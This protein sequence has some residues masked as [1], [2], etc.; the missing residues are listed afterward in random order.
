M[1][2]RL[3]ASANGLTLATSNSQVKGLVLTHFGGSGIVVQSGQGNSFLGNLIFE[4]GGLG[5]DLAGNGVTLNDVGDADTGSN[6]LQNFPVVSRV[7]PGTANV[8]FD[9]RIN[10]LP[11]QTYHVEL[12]SNTTCDV[13]NY[14]EGQSL[15]GGFNLTT[16]AQ[17]NALF[18]QVIST[19]LQVNTF[20]TATA[21]G[22]DG[23]TSEFSPCVTASP[24]NDSWIDALTLTPDPLNGQPANVT[25]FLDLKGQSRWY[26]F[27]VSPES[28]VILTLTNLPANFD[29]TLYKDIGKAFQTLTTPGDLLRLGAEFAPDAFSPDA[30]SPDAFSPDAFSPDAFSPDAFS[31]DAFSPDA[32]SPDA[33]SPDAFSPDAFSP[34]AFSPDAFSPDA[35]SP[36]A[37]SPDAFSPDAFSPDAFSPDAFSGA[38]SRSLLA[39]SAFEGTTS[40][41]I[42]VNTWDQTGDFYIRVR[43]RNGNFNLTTPYH[44]SVSLT[45]NI[46]LN[47]TPITTAATLNPVAGNFRTLILTNLSRMPGSAED[48]A[49]LAQQLA[50]LAGRTEV[51]GTVINVADDARV[52]AAYAQADANPA[53]PAAQNILADTI[54]EIITRYRIGNPLQYV[55]LVGGDNVLPFFRHADGAML[56]NEKNFVPPVLEN[57]PSQ[58]SLKSGYFLSQDDYGAAFDISVKGDDLPML[59]LAVGRLV[60]TAAE[61]KVVVDAYLGTAGGVLPAPG[62]LLVTGYD[63]LTDGAEAVQSQ[64]EA[65]AAVTADTLIQPRGDS[66]TATSAWT[67]SQLKDALLSARH[68]LVFLAGHFSASSALAA[69]YTTRMTTADLVASTTNFTNAIVFSPGCHTGYNLVDEH[70]VPNVTP[71]PDWASAFAQKGATLIAGTGYQYGDTDFIEYSERLYLEFSR[72]LRM[73]QGAVPVGLALMHAKQVYLA[74][75]AVLRPI[76]QKALLEATLFGL[77]MLSVNMAGQR[78]TQ[79]TSTP[80]VTSATPAA[81][82]PGAALGLASADLSVLPALSTQT[83]TLESVSQTGSVTATYLEGGS[84]VLTNPAEPVLPLERRNVSLAGTVLRGVGFR[85]GLYNDRLNILPLTGASTTE[86]RGVHPPF[87]TNVFFPVQPWSVNYFSQLTNAASGFTQLQAIPAQFLSDAASLTNGTLRQYDRM[88]FR[89]FYNNNIQTYAGNSV[90]A[91]A[92]APTIL[93]VSAVGTPSQVNFTATVLANPSV[94]VQSVWVTYTA[95]NGPFYGQ[96]QSLDLVQ[97]AADSTR[98]SATLPLSATAP[99]D[100]RYIVQAVNGVGLVS[101]STNI[102]RYFTPNLVGGPTQTTQLT[103]SAPASGVYG[104]PVNLSAT[105]TSAGRTDLRAAGFAASWQSN[106]GWTHRRERQRDP[107]DRI[108]RFAWPKPGYRLFCWLIRLLK[109]QRLCAGGHIQSQHP[110]D[111]HS[112]IGRSP[113]RRNQ[114]GNGDIVVRSPPPAGKNPLLCSRERFRQFHLPGH[115][116]L[117]RSCFTGCGRPAGWKLHVDGL[118]CRRCSFERPTGV[119]GG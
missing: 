112:D 44:L 111:S 90:P 18:S 61:A 107:D 40:E 68:D 50:Q 99:T 79:P 41:G 45:S 97:D 47:V 82:D 48:K 114:P 86:I 66:P 2:A 32:F 33:F 8:T 110:G 64:L 9:G 42:R 39:V 34:D 35:F 102:G 54:K 91:L 71:Q 11:S 55:V 16:D 51:S 28:R 60:E 3:A 77:P 1:A 87:A 108:A 117:H 109:L 95:L 13:S 96:W 49:A 19:T 88:D 36:D 43:G 30:F 83:V 27:S 94:G 76:H 101:L 63:F 70:A 118:F 85:G 23:S 74:D 113:A 81:G 78:L 103:M 14:G 46:C 31:P 24:G 21:T 29:L 89:L 58:A 93:N 84:G 67:A 5:I 22:P 104:S 12:F 105:L 10:A 92:A 17:G 20:I 65:G 52:A 6:Q 37:F 57:T 38:Q 56:G 69:D 106:S 25:Q 62:S 98:W 7:V 80:V 15:L 119:P 59:D 53:C 73:G 116:R 4:N 115:H 100:V 72:Q 75:T 26:K